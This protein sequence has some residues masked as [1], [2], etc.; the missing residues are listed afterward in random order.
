M[1]Q[2]LTRPVRRRPLE[3]DALALLAARGS[4]QGDGYSYKIAPDAY[5]LDAPASTEDPEF[6]D[7]RQ[8]ITFPFAAS[9]GRDRVGDWLDVE[10][11]DTRAHR[12]YPVAALDHFK[13]MRWPL[14]LTEDPDSR[15]YRVWIDEDA[16]L[17]WCEVFIN[18]HVKEAE[19]AF[20][21]FRSKI[22]RA[23][24]IGYRP[25]RV[26]KLPADP[27]QGQLK[28]GLTLHEVELL[29]TTLAVLP[30]NGDAV[31]RCLMDGIEGEPLAAGF[32]SLLAPFASAA[33]EMVVGGWQTKDTA[34]KPAGSSEGGQ[35]T[36][37][38]GGGA[39]ATTG[40]QAKKKEKRRG[41]GGT[42][43]PAPRPSLARRVTSALARHASTI[44]KA[45]LGVPKEKLAALYLHVPESMRAPVGNLWHATHAVLMSANA[46]TQ[47]LAKRVMEDKGLDEAAVTKLAW[48]LGAV[49]LAFQG[50]MMATAIAAA[51]VAHGLALA[52]KA[53]SYCPVASAAYILHASASPGKAMKTIKSAYALLKEKFLDQMRGSAAFAWGAV[54]NP[55][56]S[57]VTVGAGHK[58]AGDW[59]DEGAALIADAYAAAANP[60]M[61]LALFSAAFDDVRDVAEAVEMAN[62]C[63]GE[64]G[65]LSGSDSEKTFPGK[66]AD[67]EVHRFASTQ[68]DLPE[69]IRSRVLELAAKIPDE[70]LAE[71]GREERPHITARF[72][73]HGD[74]GEDGAAAV[75]GVVGG[76][77]PVKIRLGG[78]SIFAGDDFDVVKLDVEGDDLHRLHDALGDLNHID[79]HPKYQPHCTL[80]YVK[81]GMGKKYIGKSGLEG[82]EV[83]LDKLV[84]SDRERNETEILLKADGKSFTPSTKDAVAPSMSAGDMTTGGAF[85]GPASFG[86]GI[87]LHRGRPAI[88]KR[89]RRKKPGLA[90]GKT[91][92]PD[93]KTETAH[94]PAGSP[95]GGQFTTGSG[96]GSSAAGDG[97][98]KPKKAAASKAEPAPHPGSVHGSAVTVK[99][100]K[101]RAWDG[102]P[103]PLKT[104]LTKQETGQ[105][106]EAVALA[107]LKSVMGAADAR[108]LNL[109][110]PNAPIDLIEDHAP[111]E[112]K[113]GLA[114]NSKK[115][116]QWRLTFSKESA[117]EKALYET[118]SKEERAAWNAQKQKRIKER[119]DAMVKV[120]EKR[121]GGK[122]KPRTLT[123]IVNPDTRTADVYLFD[124]L[125]DRIGWAGPETEKAYRGSVKYDG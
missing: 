123:L 72:G 122:V 20:K 100:S 115:A 26:S 18:S 92:E 37:G 34:H 71:D 50:T 35:F 66:A 81:P 22:L 78:K 70:D 17:A 10:G 94:K 62:A 21:M 107:Y 7:R 68:F 104:A 24:S 36:S 95:E 97:G 13:W 16:G 14:G 113:A 85:I 75:R 80:A 12:L 105:V 64:G 25:L 96:G 32:K 9:L 106:G 77:G 118:M 69:P 54:R 4:N 119:K 120:L 39:A 27:E 61:W 58:T 125:H 40:A 84:Y 49:D 83:T 45:G 82:E 19:Q 28:P 11:I 52:A 63:A 124:G 5:A 53:A 29:E 98:K 101:E 102:K 30:A 90:V 56:T 93:G 89:I 31:R 59:T 103:A 33:P 109:E 44:V 46:A 48:Q 117:K 88:L 51:P 6:N 108:P 73:L 86:R 76:F 112:V 65:S 3:P 1:T 23:G 121:T 91:F 74:D 111:T 8:S 38:G 55:L 110:M 114:G 57:A 87:T 99:P 47:A 67:G 41:S 2:L 15:E 42:S 116:Q 79:T 43:A 60:D